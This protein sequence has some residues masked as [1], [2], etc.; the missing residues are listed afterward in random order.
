[1]ENSNLICFNCKFY[2]WKSED[3]VMNKKTT[4]H[5]SHYI[6]TPLTVAI[7]NIRNLLEDSPDNKQLNAIENSL[8]QINNYVKT[9]QTRSEQKR[10]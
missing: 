9:M 2:G 1:M 10:K 6:N 4:G 5:M 7:G 8:N 3:I